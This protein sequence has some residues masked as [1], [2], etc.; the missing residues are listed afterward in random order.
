VSANAPI[1]PPPP[2]SNGGGGL[3]FLGELKTLLILGLV[4]AG[5]VLVV[6]LVQDIR[7]ITRVGQEVKIRPMGQRE[8]VTGKLVAL[9][10]IAAAIWLL[11][12]V[13]FGDGPAAAKFSIGQIVYTTEPEPRQGEVQAIF[14]P[15]SVNN[16]EYIY[17]VLLLAEGIVFSYPESQ[18]TAPK[19]LVGEIVDTTEAT[20]R[21]GAVRT[22]YAPHSFQNSAD[23]YLY[24][25]LLLGDTVVTPFYESQLVPVVAGPPAP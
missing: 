3:G 13:V 11:R 10:A 24:D 2:D 17:N 14:P 15:G 12:G 5:G 9:G 4:V 7:G 22:I 16:S 21:R 1:P 18:L 20:P 8:T 19:F 6:G 25:V 23:Q